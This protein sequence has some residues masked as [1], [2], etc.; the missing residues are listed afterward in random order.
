MLHAF[1]HQLRA[2]C[3]LFI[4]CN[5]V[6]ESGACEGEAFGQC[7]VPCLNDCT[8]T[9]SVGYIFFCLILHPHTFC[10]APFEDL[11]EAKL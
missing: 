7:K 10:T 9:T 8:W 3:S 11:S 4:A 6:K 2:K 1:V 5:A